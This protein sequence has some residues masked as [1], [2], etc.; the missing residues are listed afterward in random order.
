MLKVGFNFSRVALGAMALGQALKQQPAS[1]IGIMAKVAGVKSSPVSMANNRNFQTMGTQPQ[2]V[3]RQVSHLS[4]DDPQ[5]QVAER[6]PQESSNRRIKAPAP[7]PTEKMIQQ[8]IQRKFFEGVTA[9][10]FK[11]PDSVDGARSEA[12]MQQMGIDLS[13]IKQKSENFL[14]GGD[15]EQ[16]SPEDEKLALEL[17]QALKNREKSLQKAEASTVQQPAN[18]QSS[19]PMLSPR[20]EKMALSLREALR[21]REQKMQDAEDFPLR[22][23]DSSRAGKSI[24]PA[25]FE[26]M[27]RQLAG[28]LTTERNSTSEAV[29]SGDSQKGSLE[30]ALFNAVRARAQRMQ[31]NNGA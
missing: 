19:E 31:G 8:A 30:Q 28:S 16:L 3:S 17:G 25:H 11:R 20:E 27:S 5:K 1:T 26:N 13:E 29:E 23:R 6:K 15:N 2:Q 21:E 9:G 18:E 22:E 4:V 14:R 7:Q 10:Q 12:K 24:S